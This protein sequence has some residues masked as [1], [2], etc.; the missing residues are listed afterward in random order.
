MDSLP[1]PP[2]IPQPAQVGDKNIAPT[3]TAAQDMVGAG[4]RRVNLI[5]ETMQA[6]IAAAVVGS[7]LVVSARIALLVLIPTATEKQTAIANTA[8]MLISNL[9]SLVIGF[10]FGRTNHTRT[11]GVGTEKTSIGR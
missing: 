4:Q 6:V 1:K 7:S 2:E 10:Y 8:Y 5:W 11:G 9:V 3:T